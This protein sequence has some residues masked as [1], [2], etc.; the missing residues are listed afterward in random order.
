MD[1]LPFT[2]AGQW[3]DCDRSWRYKKEKQMEQRSHILRSVEEFV[4][5]SFEQSIILKINFKF[6]SILLFVT[7]VK[8]CAHSDA[9][10]S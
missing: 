1:L 3:G 6:A 10:D 7:V 4:S 2:L 8:P 5:A 9:I